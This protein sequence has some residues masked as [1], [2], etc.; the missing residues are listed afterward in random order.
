MKPDAYSKYNDIVSAFLGRMEGFSIIP[1][2]TGIINK[3][4]KVETDD[5]NYLLQ[6]I[7]TS[8]FHNP[9]AM[10]KNASIVTEH[11][12]LKNEENGIM[13]PRRSIV[14][15]TLPD[16]RN[17]YVRKGEYWR[18]SNFIDNSASYSESHS[19]EIMYKAGKAFGHFGRM[20]SDIDASSLTE[21]IPG[22]H[23]TAKRL[24]DFH[25]ALKRD[26]IESR[27]EE[28]EAE[29]GIVEKWGEWASVLSDM[30]RNGE[31]PLRVTHND[32]KT[33]NILF[34]KDTKEF[35]AIIDLDTVMP[36]LIAYDFADS[37]RFSAN[38]AEEDEVD[39]KKVSL[40][41]SLFEAYSRGFL[42]EAG[43]FLTKGE[44]ESLVRG[45]LTITFEQGL[46][47]LQDYLTGD[48][49]YQT[50]RPGQNKD[51]ARCQFRLFE[52]IVEKQDAMNDIIKRLLSK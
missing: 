23:D 14:F 9:E 10:M 51:R 2:R 48:N 24:K 1:I 8:V 18:M 20:L 16:G 13:D 5:G 44:K 35:L 37:I 6:A 40:D 47:F 4:F 34:D 33:N 11:I 46:R 50:S 52:D 21:T 3:T 31:L 39:T 43:S 42:E 17:Y 45:T 19:P 22:F 32:T 30:A 36:G 28:M 7:N 41:L 26:A 27:V 38:T 15:K 29:L 25:E 12:R 49:Y